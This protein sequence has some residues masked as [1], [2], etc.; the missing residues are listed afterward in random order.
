MKQTKREHLLW[1]DMARRNEVGLIARK[2]NVRSHKE[3][4]HTHDYYEFFFVI[5]GEG[6]HGINGR[7]RLL[8]P[9]MLVFIRPD[10]CHHL[11]GKGA[12][13][14]FVNVSFSP[15]ITDRL[16]PRIKEIMGEVREDAFER[17]MPWTLYLSA[18]G[19]EDFENALERLSHS[20]RDELSCEAFILS[21][22]DLGRESS[23]KNNEKS[24]VPQWLAQAVERIREPEIFRGGASSFATLTGRSLEHVGRQTR[25]YYGCTPMQLIQRARLSYAAQQLE[26]GRMNISELAYACGYESLS[27]FIRLFHKQYGEAPLRYRRRRI[28]VA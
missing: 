5:S 6:W 28:G 4:L 27:H 22:L 10:D 16:V 20:A 2:I 17:E 7:R 13:L 1:K 9:G 15:K 21:V 8:E 26:M 23:R 18:K 14:E 12:G 24:Q 11:L 25:R 3:F 19:R